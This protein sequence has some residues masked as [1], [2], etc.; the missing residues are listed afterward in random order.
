MIRIDIIQMS[1][2]QL[3][4]AHRIGLA[5]FL[6]LCAL[7]PTMIAFGVLQAEN[8]NP[9][10]VDRDGILSV[11]FNGF[12]LPV[13]FPMIVLILVSLV[14]RE[15]ISNNTITYLWV[16]PISRASIVISKSLSAVSL[17]LLLAGASTLV[18]TLMLVPDW[19][20][21]L[22]WLVAAVITLL[23]YGAFFLALSLYMGRAILVGFFYILV[24]EASFSRV[25]YLAERLSI[26]FY[27]ENLASGLQGRE[28][29]VSVAAS[30]VV[31]LVITV[32]FLIL[33]VR[34]FSA[35]EFPG[36]T[37]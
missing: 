14:L 7:L 28:S 5:L 2:R 21:A 19:T 20:F 29:D 12:Q 23:A 16:K 8:I 31:L 32:F 24:W 33:S 3:V 27:G 35:M 15:E 13:L 6:V 17:A 25:S 11:L 1:L 22:N 10:H 18:T 9:G 34:R 36:D 26:R 37:E 4:G 30:L